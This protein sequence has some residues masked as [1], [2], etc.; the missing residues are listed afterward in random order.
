MASITHQEHTLPTSPPDPDNIPNDNEPES[1]DEE[2]EPPALSAVPPAA[3]VPPANPVTPSVVDTTKPVVAP[4]VSPQ[5]AAT[6]PTV[7]IGPDGKPKKQRSKRVWTE[8]QKQ[9]NREHLAR[10]RKMPRKKRRTKAEIEREAIANATLSLSTALAEQ[11]LS[12]MTSGASVSPP[13]TAT[14]D[15][16]TSSTS[17]AK[18][19]P[20][21]TKKRKAPVVERQEE[22]NTDTQVTVV[23]VMQDSQQVT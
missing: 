8:E 13:V 17:A 3:T 14:S 15:S 20:Q 23:P 16:N 12:Q 21:Q 11:K 22:D 5:P 6:T 2:D 7:E 10:I 19:T 4:V 18:Q 1:D 9:K